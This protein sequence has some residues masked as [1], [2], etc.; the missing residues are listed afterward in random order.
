MRPRMPC[1]ARAA[2]LAMKA[3]R[4]RRACASSRSASGSTSRMRPESVCRLANPVAEIRRVTAWQLQHDRE[5]RRRAR[6]SPRPVAAPWTAR[7]T[8]AAAPRGSDR[9]RTPPDRSDRRWRRSRLRCGASCAMPLSRQ[10]KVI[11]IQIDAGEAPRDRRIDDV[12]TVAR[13]AAQHCQSCRP[14]A[15]VRRSARIARNGAS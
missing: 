6:A 11:R 5:A 14:D 12:Q 7:C 1:R 13:T 4:D 10:R 2:L 8:R 3:R 9:N 15:R